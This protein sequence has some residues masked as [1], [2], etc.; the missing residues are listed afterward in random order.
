M[1]GKPFTDFR[2]QAHYYGL[3]DDVVQRYPWR[4]EID[5]R[6]IQH[7]IVTSILY[8]K[9]VLLNDGYLISN[10]MAVRDLG[11]SGTS[12]IGAALRS[13]NA[14]VFTRCAGADLVSGFERTAAS[15]TYHQVLMRDKAAW[16]RMKSDLREI[17]KYISSDYLLWPRD[18]N[19]GQIFHTLL[20][21]VANH[22]D[23]PAGA[24]LDDTLRQDFLSVFAA[25]DSLRQPN[26]DAAMTTLENA[27]LLHFIKADRVA[28]HRSRIGPV[29]DIDDPLAIG[30]IQHRLTNAAS[31]AIRARIVPD[32]TRVRSVMN[33]A[34]EVYHNAYAAAAQRSLD[35]L[36]DAPVGTAR[37][38]SD[39]AGRRIGVTTACNTRFSDL[40]ATE[41]GADPGPELSDARASQLCQLLIN[42]P[43]DL[44][45]FDDFSF[46]YNISGHAD[47]RL[48]RQNYLTEL[49]HF[50]AYGSNFQAARQARAEYIKHLCRIMAPSIRR[51]TI[52]HV[53]GILSRAA[54]DGAAPVLAA[55]SGYVADVLRLSIDRFK[56]PLI[57]RFLETP[58]RGLHQGRLASA[59]QADGLRAVQDGTELQFLTDQGFYQGPLDREGVSRL[60]V[61][62]DP[63]PDIA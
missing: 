17:N 12:L 37:A 4:Y 15:V 22:M 40:I 39:L 19:M 58:G 30:D 50:I 49:Q 42:V 62:I 24:V 1:A 53:I 38:H 11:N 9:I 8:G 63:H 25:Y 33:V 13:R 34:N 27:C 3:L 59:L 35:L 26:Y 23:S 31:S 20:A 48:A 6:S 41:V 2:S 36:S 14:F 52:E 16:T 60:L 46:I 18:K 61:A 7:H 44:T 5:Y 51:T 55:T 32:Y 10:P 47:T 54:F 45:F 43:A 21:R 28:P 57:E 29:L 56:V